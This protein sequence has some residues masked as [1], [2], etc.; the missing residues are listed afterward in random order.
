MKGF[1]LLLFFVLPLGTFAQTHKHTHTEL[2]S[3]LHANTAINLIFLAHNAQEATDFAKETVAKGTVLLLLQGGTEPIV[4]DTDSLFEQKY[5]VLYF[6]LACTA[7][8]KEITMAYNNVVFNHLSKKYGNAW[9]KEVRKDV[10]G[11][12]P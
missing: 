7:P 1:Q 5:G 12:K 4:Y 11:F 9:K 8:A 6:D 10:I 2:D 3:A